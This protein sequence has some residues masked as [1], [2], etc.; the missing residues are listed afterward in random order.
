MGRGQ[1]EVVGMV[2]TYGDVDVEK[3]SIALKELAEKGKKP[4]TNT[5]K[6][7]NNLLPHPHHLLTTQLI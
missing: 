2:K 1:V 6:N 7:T 3:I 5:N 4:D